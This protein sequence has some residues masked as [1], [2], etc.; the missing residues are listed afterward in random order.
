MGW[1][2]SLGAGEAGGLR[3]PLRL[4]LHPEVVG[5]PGVASGEERG[6]RRGCRGPFCLRGNARRGLHLNRVLALPLVLT[7]ETMGFRGQN[8]RI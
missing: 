3:S 1:R 2:L 6:R 5:A 8:N 4:A 7:S